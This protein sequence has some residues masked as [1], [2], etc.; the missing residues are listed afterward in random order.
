CFRSKNT[1][2][3]RSPDTTNEVDR[4][5]PYGVI[6]FDP[7]KKHHRKRNDHPG[8][9][10]D[11]D[12]FKWSHQIRPRG[13]SHQTTED[14]IEHHGKIVRFE[15]IKRAKIATNRTGGTSYGGIDKYE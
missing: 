15:Q 6:N 11:N 14:S 10:S 3:H 7:V 1:H 5:S 13:D 8:D 4:S 9:G 2:Y 12:R